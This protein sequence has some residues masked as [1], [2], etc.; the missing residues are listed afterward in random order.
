MCGSEQFTFIL[1]YIYYSICIH[2]IHVL[3][4]TFTFTQRNFSANTFSFM[5][6]AHE[7]IL[8]NPQLYL[9]LIEHFALGKIWGYLSKRY[10]IYVIK[11]Y[12]TSSWGFSSIA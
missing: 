2:M 9:T 7:N 4:Q 1:F 8:L 3:K 6:Y 11:K 10:A 5:I 12:K